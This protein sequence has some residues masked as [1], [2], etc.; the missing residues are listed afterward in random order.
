M[1]IAQKS[2]FAEYFAIVNAI[3]SKLFLLTMLFPTLFISWCVKQEDNLIVPPHDW[4]F[5]DIACKHEEYIDPTDPDVCK[6][7]QTA[8]H[9]YCKDE[10]SEFWVKACHTE[11]CIGGA[12]ACK[13]EDEIKDD[14]CDTTDCGDGEKLGG[15]EDDREIGIDPPTEAPA[16]ED[17][18]FVGVG[19]DICVGE[20]IV[21]I[22]HEPVD[23][24]D[25]QPIIYGIEH[26]PAETGI[27]KQ[28]TFKVDNPFDESVDIHVRYQTT[29]GEHAADPACNSYEDVPF[30]CYEPAKSV[31]AACID[32]PHIEAFALVDVYIVTTDRNVLDARLDGDVEQCC[33]ARDVEGAGVVKYSFKILVAYCL[34]VDFVLLVSLQHNFQRK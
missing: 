22:I 5:E 31:W 16:C 14:L 4:T 34:L 26:K 33:H 13:A 3:Q 29:V 18:D 23:I 25:G 28:V 7:S 9:Q 32:Y 8:I 12:N 15:S 2:K 21:K 19:T 20:D 17:N 6:M 1:I 11:C 24:P 27:G 30:G 10:K